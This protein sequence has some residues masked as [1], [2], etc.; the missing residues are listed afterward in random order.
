MEITNEVKTTHQ[1]LSSV[2]T[3]FL[4]FVRKNP[5][6][7]NRSNFK[8]LELNDDLFRLQPW[9]TFV[10]RKARETF[11]EASVTLFNLIKGIPRRVFNND[12][13]AMSRYYGVTPSVLEIQMDGVHDDHLENLL[14]RG[15]FII[16]SSGLKCL[17]YN[18]TPNLGGWQVPIWES[19]YLNT[20]LIARFLKEYDIK[21]KNENL[22][23]L[24]LKHMV[25]CSLT[26]M[27][28]DDNE[29]NL[30]LV[31]KGYA[32][33]SERTLET[34][35]DKLYKEI[36]S[37][38]D[39]P[40]TG[41]IFFCDYPHLVREDGYLFYKEKRVHALTELYLGMVPPHVI[42]VF[43][44]G[45]L[46]LVNGPITNLLSSKLNLAL[47]SDYDTTGVFTG[48][49]KRI[50]D[51]Y[52]PWTRKMTPGDTTHEGEKVNLMDFIRSNR[53]RLV[54]KPSVGYGGKGVWIG[55]NTPAEEWE[56]LAK[57]GVEEGNWAVQEFT[58]PSLGLYQ[59]GEEG[60]TPQDIVWGF[61]VFGSRYSGAW[62]RVMPRD[63]SK[64]VINC[65]QGATVS[66]IFEVDD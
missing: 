13:R 64:G 59:A 41:T 31:E 58:P 47:L 54:L 32:A 44:A 2:N 43:K 52:V 21:I 4:E 46:R 40:L 9:P 33:G 30:A 8:L 19:L 62:A 24:F 12:L 11:T 26:K 63:N 7:L 6:C 38:L 34:Y 20:P 50:I 61:F 48:E 65:H 1:R 28:G 36:L 35:L 56:Q 18:V 17:E 14:A 53:E 25:D 16:S 51:R 55:K 66:I 22:L 29:L 23:Y 49:E 39:R 27:S 37:R 45:N 57:T 5:A 42:N 15:D 60:C 3:D 10:N